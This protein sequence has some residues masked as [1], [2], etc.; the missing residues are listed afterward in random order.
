[1]DI[2]NMTG[3]QP[4]SGPVKHVYY[5]KG[6]GVGTESLDSKAVQMVELMAMHLVN[7]T[8]S[9]LNSAYFPQIYMIRNWFWLADFSG[10][11]FEQHM[12][13]VLG[14]KTGNTIKL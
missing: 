9:V 1:M 13:Q 5:L 7:N 4:V 2:L 3:L 11:R 14:G 12:Y 6:V 8:A 10:L